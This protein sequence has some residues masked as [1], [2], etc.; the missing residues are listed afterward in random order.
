M[1][2][3]IKH[4][5][6]RPPDDALWMLALGGCGE[7]GMNMYLYGTAGRWLMVD[8]GIMFGDDTT[9]GI[10]IIT[11]DIGFIAERREDLVGIVITHGHEDHLGAIE[12]LWPN[13]RCPIYAAPFPA[14][15]LRRKMAQAGFQDVADIRDIPMGA[16]F[17]LAPFHIEM[18]PVT[19]SVP[20]SQM[21]LIGTPFGRILH[22]GD[23]KFDA[24]PV[25]GRLTDDSRLK[26]L[27]DEGVLALV[28]DSTGAIVPFP[29]PSE[30]E[31][32][33]GLVALFGQR[34][35]RI[36]VTCFS[37]NIARVKSTVLAAK[38]QGR[39][40][41]LV[42][43]SLWRNAEIAESL[44]Y[45]PEY[46]DFLSEHEAMQVPRDKIVMICTGCQ[47]ERRAALS[48]I[49]AFDHPIVKLERDDVVFFSSRDIPGNEKSIARVQNL[50]LSRRI[51]VITSE[52]L[53]RGQIIHASGHAARPDMERLYAWTRP[54]IAIPVHG[55]VRHQNEHAGLARAAGVQAVII[56]KNG[57]IVRVA[58]G[59]HEVVAEV[60]AGR[61]GLDGK[62]LRPLD[63]TVAQNR[64]KM[65]FN[66][67]AIATIVLDRHGM[68]AGEPQLSLMGI[69]DDR[70]IV[71]LRDELIG[72]IEDEVGSMAR[73]TLLDDEAIRQAVAKIIRKHLHESQGKKP[74]IEVHLVRV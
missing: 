35:G 44:G 74:V 27:G 23:W 6:H 30:I 33:N 12:R 70:T 61:W 36:V 68:L 34:K 41:S 8:C 58:P 37:S 5:S 24:H 55:E 17:D 39:H 53:E 29:T 13:L 63:Q 1:V 42:G 31:V 52:H 72:A 22:T 73:A 10:D 67:A 14:A 11:P 49:A 64:R 28:G 65:G 51:Q 38:A 57:Q 59:A 20:E 15:M 66:G 54:R 71:S 16:S 9:P 7:I 69:D 60:K 48:R 56:P 47:G 3:H 40:I 45:L 50:L 18:I 26:A 62:N 25:V 46:G 19:H 4:D 43:R 32:Q 21:V 2:S